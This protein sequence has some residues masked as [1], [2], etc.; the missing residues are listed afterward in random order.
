MFCVR[1][2]VTMELPGQSVLKTCPNDVHSRFSVGLIA[3]EIAWPTLKKPFASR[4]GG[5]KFT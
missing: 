4:V 3:R 2:D 1:V 5:D